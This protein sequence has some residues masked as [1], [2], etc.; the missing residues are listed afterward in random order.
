MPTTKLGVGRHII[1]AIYSG[2]VHYASATSETPVSVLVAPATT[3]TTLSS[4]TTP[5]GTTLTARV[6]VTS[7]GDPPIVG[8]VSFYEGSTLLA[9]VPVIDGVATD[10]LGV[11]PSGAHSFSAIFTG[12]GTSSS[13]ALTVTIETDGPEITRVLRYGFHSYPTYLLIDFDTQLDAAAAEDTA[14]FKIVGPSGHR[15]KVCSASMTQRPSRSPW[16][17]ISRSTSTRPTA[18][19]SMAPGPPACRL[20]AAC[21]CMGRKPAIPAATM[22]RRSPG[23]TSPARRGSCRPSACSIQPSTPPPCTPRLRDTTPQ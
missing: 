5:Q 18:C 1:T 10:D 21:S 22:R 9:T 3:A 4:T 8:T 23:E 14:N 6:V 7:P 16:F 11:L 19:L 20:P 12:N 15:I 17:P 13:S 2:D